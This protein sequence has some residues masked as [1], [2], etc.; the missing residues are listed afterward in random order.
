VSIL[1]HAV[2]VIFCVLLA[3]PAILAQA[4][5][6]PPATE[7]FVQANDLPPVEQLP[8]APLVIGAYGCFLVL[9]VGYAWSI[10]RRL[11]TVEAEMRAL[12]QRQARG[13]GPR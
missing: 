13:S 10:A 7:G 3:A 5:Q 12:E 6:R 1:R 4:P 11:N 2:M 9:M 8:A